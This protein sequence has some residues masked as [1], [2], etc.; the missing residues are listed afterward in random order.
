MSKANQQ[1]ERD[2]QVLAMCFPSVIHRRGH[3][4][5]QPPPSPT[6]PESVASL[7]ALPLDRGSLRAG[8][9][10][11]VPLH[12][13]GLAQCPCILQSLHQHFQHEA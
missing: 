12:P 8:M 4:C 1:S 11:Q 10:C 5:D 2:P 13:Q 6:S 7:S 3:T 9:M